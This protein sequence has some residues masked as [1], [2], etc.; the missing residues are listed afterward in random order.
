[1][2]KHETTFA[3]T[4]KSRCLLNGMTVIQLS[5]KTGISR[6]TFTR[7]FVDG[8]W[9]REQLQ[10]MDRFLHFTPDD[11]QIFLEGK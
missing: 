9:N 4:V 3:E 10:Q 11:L 1:M 5:A 8:N 7:R 6:A 2:R